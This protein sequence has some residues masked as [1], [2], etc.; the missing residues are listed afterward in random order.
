MWNKLK[1]SLE[2]AG[3]GM[4]GGLVIG[5]SDADWLRLAIALALFAYAGSTK[6]N[7]IPETATDSFRKTFTGIAAFVAVFAGLYLNGH[8]IFEKTPGEAVSSLTEA[9]YTPSQAREIYKEQIENQMSATVSPSPS[10]EKI[11]EAFSKETKSDS[12]SEN[13]ETI[14]PENDSILPE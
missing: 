1:E 14:L 5:L 6:K 8:Q 3:I 12:L 13:K 7:L 11:I 10:I 9:G 4:L 2:G